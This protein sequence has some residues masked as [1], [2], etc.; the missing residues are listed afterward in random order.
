MNFGE[1]L[2]LDVK[3]IIKFAFEKVGLKVTAGYYEINASKKVLENQGL[4][5]KVQ[6]KMIDY[7]KIK[8][9]I[10]LTSED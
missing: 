3:R 10:I 5:M 9:V 4:N 1:E 2:Q 7:L 8:D 6:E